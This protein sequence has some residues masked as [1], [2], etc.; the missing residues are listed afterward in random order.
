VDVAAALARFEDFTK[1]LFN[2][3]DHPGKNQNSSILVQVGRQCIELRVTLNSLLNAT[4]EK[5][6]SG[7]DQVKKQLS[8]IEQAIPG[9]ESYKDLRDRLVQMNDVVVKKLTAAAS[10]QGGASS[11]AGAKSPPTNSAIVLRQ[12]ECQVISDDATRGLC[13]RV[14]DLAMLQRAGLPVGWTRSA[15]PNVFDDGC[16]SVDGVESA[17][18]SSCRGTGLITNLGW[19]GNALIMIGGWLLTAL[20]CTLG[21]PF[22]FD[23]LSKLVKLRASG[24]KPDD[25]NITGGSTGAP[26]GNL[27]TRSTSTTASAN[28]QNP[29]PIPMSDVLNDSERALSRAQVENIQRAL[30]I[31]VAQICGYFDDTTRLAIQ[32]WQVNRGDPG[33]GELSAAQISILING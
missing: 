30:K 18:D 27:L 12:R 25:S 7:S 22:W 20:A 28:S 8:A 21:A 10:A 13:E 14:N 16:V 9:N 26:S 5:L 19:L 4:P 17:R 23:A 32:N 2:A 6:A 1:E 15:F 11:P 31:P 24:A 29:D 33:T 3:I